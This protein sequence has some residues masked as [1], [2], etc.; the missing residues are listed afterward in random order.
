MASMAIESRNLVQMVGP[1]ACYR[2]KKKA[3]EFNISIKFK[4]L[5]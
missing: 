5:N 2:K 1:A 3:I 4:R